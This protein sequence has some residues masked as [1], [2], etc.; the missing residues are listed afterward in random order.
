MRLNYPHNLAG[1]SP[2]ARVGTKGDNVMSELRRTPW[3]QRFRSRFMI[4]LVVG[5]LS[6]IVAV[7][8]TSGNE[9]ARRSA[10]ALAERLG[11]APVVFPGDHGGFMAD[12]AAF[13]GTIRQLLT[14]SREVLQ[15]AR[16]VTIESQGR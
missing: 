13:A 8:A 11:T 9:I 7:G 10:E 14:Q 2:S 4:A 5:A 15:P 6:V 3:T 12:P 1:T 16:P